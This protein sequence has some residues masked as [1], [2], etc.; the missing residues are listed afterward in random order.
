MQTHAAISEVVVTYSTLTTTIMR[1]KKRLLERKH[2]VIRIE[3][4][5]DYDGGRSVDIRGGARASPRHPRV[6]CRLKWGPPMKA[7]RGPHSAAGALRQTPRRR[8][9]RPMM[10]PAAEI[11]PALRRN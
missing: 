11:R 3:N 6:A 7:R 4:V 8:S 2:P 10:N 5:T 9:R 1:Y